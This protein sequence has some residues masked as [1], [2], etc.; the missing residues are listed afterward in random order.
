MPFAEMQIDLEAVRQSKVRKK[1]KIAYHH[2]CGGGK[3]RWDEL[4]TG[5]DI[6]ILLCI[7]YI[8]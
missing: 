7:K 6:Y 3:G 2:I 4:E 5:T 1:K 8:N